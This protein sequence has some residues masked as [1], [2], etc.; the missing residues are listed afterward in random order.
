MAVTDSS[1]VSPP[2]KAAKGLVDNSLC[3]LLPVKDAELPAPDVAFPLP[4][5]PLPSTEPPRILAA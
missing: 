1:P 5:N 4:T 3:G 2:A